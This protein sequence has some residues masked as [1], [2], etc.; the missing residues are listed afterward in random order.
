MPT[1]PVNSAGNAVAV[2]GL[3]CRFPG[4]R[5][6]HEFAANLNAGTSSIGQIEADR[7]DLSRFYSPDVTAPGRSVSKWCGMVEEPYGFDHLFFRIS[8][9]E[10]RS[11]DPQQRLLLQESWNC[12]EDSGIDLGHLRRARTSVHMGV[13]GRDHLQAAT[14]P[15]VPVESHS[16]LGGYDCLLANRVSHVL[17]LRGAS[18]SVDAACASSLVSVHMAARS[19]TQ[20]ET[21]FALAGGVSLNLHPWKYISFSKARMLSPRGLCRTFDK[22][23]DGYVP[24]DGVAVL[25]LRRLEDAERDGDHV[26]GVIRG[27][28]VNHGGNRP[29]ITAPTVDSQ[30]D[31]VTAALEGSGTDPRTVG[32]VEAHGTGTSLGD[33]VEV[34]ALRRVFTEASQDTGWCRIGS[35]KPNIG[36]L[37]AAAGAA[38]LIK[39]LMMMRDRVVPPSVHISEPNPLIDFEDGPFR[40]ALAPEDWTS[41]E[42]DEP[43][44]AGVSSFGMGGVNAHIDRKSVV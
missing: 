37:E 20:G 30:V 41:E 1:T 38:G 11:M 22:S 12:V 6:H 3:S 2:V 39:V 34:E 32:Y 5:N 10:A 35:V 23:A 26:Y 31:V 17:G 44:R 13:M 19:L 16:G 29:T 9:R 4:A 24:G 25:L 27:G 40:L 36:H 15:G 43:L 21:D 7:W 18:V 28:A 33:P 8:R 42:P 14:D